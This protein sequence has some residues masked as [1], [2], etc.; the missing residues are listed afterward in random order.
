VP[1]PAIDYSNVYT[2]NQK[3]RRSSQVLLP[4]RP[5]RARFAISVR[6]IGEILR[7]FR[8]SKISVRALTRF[9]NP[10]LWVKI[11]QEDSAVST[12]RGEC[13]AVGTESRT[14]STNGVDRE[15]LAKGLTGRYIP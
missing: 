6:V 14:V 12:A 13:L 5:L 11:P 15:R 2:G 1:A 10:G 7:P 4:R 8:V 3:P 9:F